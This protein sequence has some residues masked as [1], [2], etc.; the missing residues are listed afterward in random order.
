MNFVRSASMLTIIF[1]R[2]DRAAAIAVMVLYRSL[3]DYYGG[4]FFI[5]MAVIAV[6]VFYELPAFF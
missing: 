6:A 2:S 5:E 4:A 1:I 3:K